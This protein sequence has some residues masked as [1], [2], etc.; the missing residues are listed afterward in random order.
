MDCAAATA[1]AATFE[2]AQAAQATPLAEAQSTHLAEAIGHVQDVQAAPKGRVRCATGQDRWRMGCELTCPVKG[3]VR[4]TKDVLRKTSSNLNEADKAEVEAWVVTQADVFAAC[5]KKDQVEQLLGEWVRQKQQ[6]Q[7]GFW[8]RYGMRGALKDSQLSAEEQ[9]QRRDTMLANREAG[10]AWAGKHLTTLM[11]NGHVFMQG[12]GQQDFVKRLCE[13]HKKILPDRTSGGEVH[14]RNGARIMRIL[15]PDTADQQLWTAKQVDDQTPVEVVSAAPDTIAVISLQVPTRK[16][17][18]DQARVRGWSDDKLKNECTWAEQLLQDLNQMRSVMAERAGRQTLPT[19]IEFLLSWP[20]Q[21]WQQWHEDGCYDSF[22]TGIFYLQDGSKP[23]LFAPVKHTCVHCPTNSG[24]S[25]V[26]GANYRQMLRAGGKEADKA[27]KKLE[28]A[29]DSVCAVETVP[30]RGRKKGRTA[31]KSRTVP[32]DNLLQIYGSQEEVDKALSVRNA[33]DFQLEHPMHV[34]RA[35]P[36]PLSG[37]GLFRRVVFVAWDSH[38]LANASLT[39]CFYDNWRTLWQDDTLIEA[40]QA[41]ARKR[42]K[43]DKKPPKPQ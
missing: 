19:C 15:L 8:P 1:A 5:H 29:W 24:G 23:T 30:A 31:S 27:I 34:H 14:E 10:K 7:P 2:G 32:S 3:T 22:L 17:L 42:F 9:T 35:P 40:D 6:T 41:Q 12:Q 43:P 18:E 26:D 39:T 38:R 25:Q 33:G 16:Q 28:T 11:Q 20:G 13:F 37:S 21:K 36:P 4:Y